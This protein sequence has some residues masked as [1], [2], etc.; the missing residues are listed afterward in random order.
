MARIEITGLQSSESNFTRSELSVKGSE[1]LFNTESYLEEL[2]D[3]E[4]LQDIRGGITPAIALS[5]AAG[6]VYG[7]YIA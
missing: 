5:F 7:R 1:L 2:T 4:D 3:Y 6:Y